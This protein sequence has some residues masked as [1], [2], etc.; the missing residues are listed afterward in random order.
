MRQAEAPGAA[1]AF[2]VCV[3]ARNEAERLPRLLE[4]LAAQ[5]HCGTIPVVVALNNTTDGSAAVVA[6]TR[7]RHGQRLDILIDEHVF[8]EH[9]AH[10]GSARRRAMELGLQQLGDP[11][12]ILIATDADARPGPGWVAANLRAI[13]AGADIVGGALRLDEIEPAPALVA[14]RRE[15]LDRYWARVR[16]IEDATDPRPWDPQPRHGDHTGASLALTAARYVAAG[17]VPLVPSGEDVALVQAVLANGGRLAHPLDVWVRVSPRASGRTPGGMAKAMA[18][19]AD[20]GTDVAAPCYAQWRDRA[21]W[22]RDL[23][24][25]RGDAAIP[26]LENALP[27]MTCDMVLD[28]GR[29]G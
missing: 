18:A 2:C 19:L 10:A 24:S 6:A 15:I 7:E 22:R 16:E 11:D 12:G 8:P 13:E 5:D 26:E 27:P 20:P 29:A 4:A 25:R 9:L 28:A 3:P 23:R 14:E 17:G 21:A 1:R